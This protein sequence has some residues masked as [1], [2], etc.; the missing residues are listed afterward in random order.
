MFKWIAKKYLLSKVN[1]L[2]KQ[3]KDNVD[4][5]NQTLKKWSQR[6]KNVLDCLEQTL[7]KLDDNVLDEN[8]LK[9]LIDVVTQLLKEW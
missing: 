6:M 8:E 9:Q 3:H 4:Q 2:L 1:G 7:A 5:A